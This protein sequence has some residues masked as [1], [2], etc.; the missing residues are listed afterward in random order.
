MKGN[1]SCSFLLASVA[2]S[3]IKSIYFS[4]HSVLKY[5]LSLFFPRSVRPLPTAIEVKYSFR[6]NVSN[7]NIHVHSMK[8]KF[9]YRVL[10]L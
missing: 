5:V 10:V 4:Q 8:T 7:K 1:T 3:V 6:F 2:T 9:K